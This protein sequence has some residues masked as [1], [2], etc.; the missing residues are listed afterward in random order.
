MSFLPP[1]RSRSLFLPSAFSQLLRVRK[2]DQMFLNDRI[3]AAQMVLHDQFGQ[4]LS[5]RWKKGT[6]TNCI[7]FLREKYE[8]NLRSKDE[9]L[10]F[11]WQGC[12]AINKRWDEKPCPTFDKRKSWTCDWCIVPLSKGIELF[13][14]RSLISSLNLILLFCICSTQL[15]IINDDIEHEIPTFRLFG[16]HVQSWIWSVCL[17]GNANKFRKFSVQ[18]LSLH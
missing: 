1:S 5:W 4:R 7:Q 16:S 3:S 9:R 11:R 2:F 17:S 15:D 8:R 14:L 10:M 18:N 12:L 6:K 13:L